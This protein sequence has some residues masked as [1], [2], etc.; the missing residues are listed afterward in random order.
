MNRAFGRSWL[1]FSVIWTIIAGA[2][3]GRAFLFFP[4]LPDNWFYVYLWIIGILLCPIILLW[5]KFL[6]HK[7]Q[8]WFGIVVIQFIIA[9]FLSV[10]FQWAT[11]TPLGTLRK[12]TST[13]ELEQMS[14]IRRFAFTFFSGSTYSVFTSFMMLSALGLLIVY[15]EQLREKKINES[16]L[17][18]NLAQIQLKVLQS[19]LHPH[20]VFNTLHT[21]SSLMESDIRSAQKLI[22]RLSMLLRT[23]LDVI[24]RHF[25]TLQEELEFI[26]EYI[27]VIQFRHSQ[28]IQLKCEV[29]S[30]LR[31]QP[32][33]VLLLQPLVENSIKHGWVNRK[34]ELR[35]EL[36]IESTIHRLVIKLHDNGEA[37]PEGSSREGVGLRNLRDRLRALYGEDFTLNHENRDG[38]HTTI[39]LPLKK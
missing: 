39:T 30:P 27:R 7:K 26:E 1:Q 9:V 35:I 2:P 34:R 12:R 37:K 21:V 16:A 15:N 10:G 25:Y 4:H 20:F 22:E 11:F 13:A 3:I 23:Y 28:S 6:Q 19:E 36:T 5:V 38:Y 17:R 29:E 8:G 33:P 31:S 18:A 32:V 24:D 14:D